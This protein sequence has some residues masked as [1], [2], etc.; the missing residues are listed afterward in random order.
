MLSSKKIKETA[1]S[2]GADLCGIA[3]IDRFED[4]PEGYHPLDVLPTCKSVISFAC[5]FPVGALICNSHIPYTR[6]RNSITSKMDA[7]ALD[8]C[9]ELEKNQI[10]CVPIPTN[11]CQWDK[12]TGRWR[13]VVSQKHAAQAAGLGTIGRHSLLITPE[14]GSMV[15]LGAI[16]C[17]QEFEPDKMQE[18]LCSNCNLC[19]EICPVNALENPEM[20]QLDCQSFAF[21]DD[22]ESQ[23][24]RIACHKCRDACPYNLGSQNSI[25]KQSSAFQTRSRAGKGEFGFRS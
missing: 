19:V 5:R 24:W 11:E 25:L 23:V 3:S 22:E 18:V 6:V 21:G 13:S 1:F 2:L 10:V 16:L 17:E 12:N 14:F 15:W 4:A 7:I 20:K 8:L 9:I